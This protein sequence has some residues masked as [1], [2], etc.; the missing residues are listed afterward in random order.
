MISKSIRS[1]VGR[2]LSLWRKNRDLANIDGPHGASL[3]LF[4]RRVGQS[5]TGLL[6]PSGAAF[7][8]QIV[9]ATVVL[10]ARLT[11]RA[12][13]IYGRLTKQSI[14]AR[15]LGN[16]PNRPYKA[17][18]YL[19]VHLQ[20]YYDCTVIPRRGRSPGLLTRLITMLARI[21]RI[22]FVVN[23]APG[24][25]HNTV[26]LD[27]FLRQAYAGELDRRAR[28]VFLRLPNNFHNDTVALYRRHFWFASSNRLLRNL[29]MPTIVANPDL[30][31]D[32][33]LSRL[34]WHLREDG[35]YSQP[36][37][38]QTFLYQISKEENREAWLRYYR[39]RARTANIAPLSDGLAPDQALLDFL[40][41]GCEKLALFHCKFHIANATAAPTQPLAYVA[42]MRHLKEQGYR[43][44][45]VG[46]EP[47]P[48]EFKALGVLNYA[49]SDIASYRHD[50]Q[51]FACAKIAVTAGSG[52]ALLPDCM[53]I[54]F[55]YCDSWHV[56]MPMASQRCVIVPSLVEE[57]L[58][59][60]TL[61]FQEQIDLYFELAD[62][63]DEIFPTDKYTARNASAEDVLAAVDEVLALENDATRPFTQLQ[64]HFR[65]LDKSGLTEASRA[66][67]S[68]AFL[69]RHADLL[70]NPKQ[71][72]EEAT[73]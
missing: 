9:Y 31:I 50:L 17:P 69:G 45:H 12:V 33:G 53:D 47:M 20:N 57:N 8:H 51:L 40:G 68:E 5:V 21:F 60:R 56:G 18:D 4:V 37:G 70:V 32:C 25:G 41:G 7:L 27:F 58:S 35:T 11:I 55:V 46:R 54:P 13:E 62:K 38:G 71:R 49:E 16:W 1:A 42:A 28:Y 30:R 22:V 63:G 15:S 65:A 73:K 6:T 61:T 44:V 2:V 64:M 43:I 26:E 67:V 23:I 52:I 34:K 39:L 14:S 66:R 36:P 3:D 24:T 10:G 59:G 19:N 48:E 72:E 29:L